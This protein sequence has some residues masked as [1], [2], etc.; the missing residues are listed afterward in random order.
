M[1]TAARL[2]FMYPAKAA[3]TIRPSFHGYYMGTKQRAVAQSPPRAHARPEPPARLQP[4]SYPIYSS[5]I[6]RAGLPLFGAGR[7][8]ANCHHSHTRLPMDAAER[9]E[10][11]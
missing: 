10:A 7:C 1:Q 11:A 4:V 2:P 9:E 6:R 8:G 5:S 3:T